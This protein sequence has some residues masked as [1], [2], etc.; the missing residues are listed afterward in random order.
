MRCEDAIVAETCQESAHVVCSRGSSTASALHRIVQRRLR[1]AQVSNQ[2][3]PFRSNTLE[4]QFH[5]V[6]LTRIRIIA[7]PFSTNSL[8]SVDRYGSR[9][10]GIGQYLR[11]I[12]AGHHT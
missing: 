2:N 8:S 10:F 11:L 4:F 1:Y 5:G 12:F 7:Y 9:L 3:S 6:G